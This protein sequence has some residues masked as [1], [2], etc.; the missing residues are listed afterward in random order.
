MGDIIMVMR[1]FHTVSA[2]KLLAVKFVRKIRAFDPIS[3]LYTHPHSN[4]ITS[5][6]SDVKLNTNNQYALCKCGY[7][8]ALC[9]LYNARI[10]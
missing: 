3:I 2:W 1:I 7:T 9:V 8:A 5:E 4:W 6:Y 10:A